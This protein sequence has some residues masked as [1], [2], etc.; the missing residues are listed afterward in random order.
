MTS[1][2]YSL[3]A[4]EDIKVDNLAKEAYVVWFS[5]A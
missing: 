4:M 2:S 3:T 5:Q 1:V